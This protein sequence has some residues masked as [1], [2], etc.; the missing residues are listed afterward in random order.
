[1]AIRLDDVQRGYDAWAAKPHNSKWVRKIDG[2][3]IANDIVVNIFEALKD[4][5]LSAALSQP[6]VKADTRPSDC[7][8]RLQDEG[9]PYP[10]SG[11]SACKNSITS[12]LGRYCHSAPSEPKAPKE[13]GNAEYLETAIGLIREAKSEPR[14]V[15]HLDAAESWLDKII[16][17][18]NNR[19]IDQLIAAKFSLSEAADRITALEKENAELRKALEPFA[20]AALAIRTAERMTRREFH[21]DDTFQSGVAWREGDKVKTVTYGDFRRAR[22]A[23]TERSG[24]E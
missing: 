18:E 11:C 13:I 4:A 2:T 14:P 23:S 10:R 24:D 22:L 17:S 3:P 20:Q 12:G 6:E 7:R 8:F 16:L 5:T 21:D 9:K 19:L 15:D 1:M